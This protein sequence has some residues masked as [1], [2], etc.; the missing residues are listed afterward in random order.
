[1]STRLNIAARLVTLSLVCLTALAACG[2]RGPLEPPPNA[3]AAARSEGQA[4][5]ARPAPVEASTFAGATTV[6]PMR[7]T[8]NVTDEPVE[9][10]PPPPTPA[11]ASGPPGVT[12]V[13][14]G[15]A[16]LRA[17]PRGPRR[18][19]PPNTPFILDPLL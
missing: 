15:Q 5:Q 14:P 7:E 3:Q 11:Q 6:R 9:T 19:P 13:D 1:M 10:P 12:A 17:Q 4:A 16:G 8:E 18:S 2:R